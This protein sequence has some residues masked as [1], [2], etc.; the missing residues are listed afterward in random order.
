MHIVSVI[1]PHSKIMTASEKIVTILCFHMKPDDTA[2][3]YQCFIIII[4]LY[5]TWFIA[6][7]FHQSKCKGYGHLEGVIIVSNYRTAYHSNILSRKDKM[8][9][10]TSGYNVSLMGFAFCQMERSLCLYRLKDIIRLSISICLPG[11][12]LTF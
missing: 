1:Q 7:P 4:L 12:V 2:F 5:Y 11:L 9:Q 6:I 10:C 3:F 8:T